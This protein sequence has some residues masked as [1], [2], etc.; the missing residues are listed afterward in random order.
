ML[1]FHRH[2][3][4]RGIL[5]RQISV[6]GGSETGVTPRL[7]PAILFDREQV[8]MTSDRKKKETAITRRFNEKHEK[9]EKVV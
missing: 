4:S 5:F 6:E 3:R 8:F 9:K 2:D 7:W 1:F